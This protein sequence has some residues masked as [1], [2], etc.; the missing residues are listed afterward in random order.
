MCGS[1]PD[2]E[3]VTRSTGIGVSGFSSPE[4]I[5][6]RFHVRLEK[7]P[8]RRPQICAARSRRVISAA[9]RR[10]AR[11]KITRPGE[12]LTDK[13]RPYHAAIFFYKTACCLLWKNHL[14]QPCHDERINDSQQHC[15]RH[16]DRN[17]RID[18][19]EYVHVFSC[20]S[21]CCDYQVNDL[22]ADERDDDAAKPVD[23]AG[24]A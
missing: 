23:R 22:D 4:R 18:L 11:V 10:R 1:S 19:F 7:L 3:A 6:S 21:N 13:L 12:W 24:C 20:Q 2:A 16:S 5:G 9:S 14:R 15:E 8:A 17:R